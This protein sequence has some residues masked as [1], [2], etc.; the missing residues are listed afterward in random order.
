MRHL[1]IKTYII[2]ERAVEEGIA[3]GLKRA[4]KHHENPSQDHIAIEIEKAVM[5][6]LSEVIDFKGQTSEPFEK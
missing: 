5:F 4:R 1:Q 3:Y 6:S 2:V